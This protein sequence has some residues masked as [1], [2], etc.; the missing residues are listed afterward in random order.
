[1]TEEEITNGLERCFGLADRK[2]AGHPS[3]M[4]EAF[5]L[6]KKLRKH[7]VGWG[8]VEKCVRRLLSSNT[9]LNVD[10]QVSEVK[11][12]YRPWILD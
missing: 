3:D 7:H 10:E 2:F 1:M 4:I 5:E 9:K 6:L 11:K 12:Y 8:E